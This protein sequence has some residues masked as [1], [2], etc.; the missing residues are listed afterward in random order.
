MIEREEN[1]KSDI[2]HAYIALL[3]ATKPSEDNNLENESME[4]QDSLLSQLQEQVCNLLS[5]LVKFF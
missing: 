1:V 3:R 4:Q 5:T 2:F